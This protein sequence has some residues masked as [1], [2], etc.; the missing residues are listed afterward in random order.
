MVITNNPINHGIK[1]R[2][3]ALLSRPASFRRW[4]FSSGVLALSTFRWE[5]SEIA[6]MRSLSE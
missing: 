5:S 4:A 6:L 3:A 2:Y 1:N